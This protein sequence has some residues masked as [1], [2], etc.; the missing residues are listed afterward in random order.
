V[1]ARARNEQSTTYAFIQ[2]ASKALEGNPDFLEYVLKPLFSPALN[3]SSK[4]PAA[5][6]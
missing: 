2:E 4:S 3:A 5:E 6:K 1:A